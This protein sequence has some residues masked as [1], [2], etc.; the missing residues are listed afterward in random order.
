MG[1]RID[2]ASVRRNISLWYV[3]IGRNDACPVNT[4][5]LSARPM[6]RPNVPCL[7]IPLC[8][9][10]RAVTACLTH[11]TIFLQCIGSLWSAWAGRTHGDL[12]RGRDRKVLMSGP[13]LL[14]L[15]GATSGRP[16]LCGRCV[17]CNLVR[18][19][20]SVPTVSML[21]RGDIGFVRR[22]CFHKLIVHHI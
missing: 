5:V 10:S 1:P 14:P 16:S 8:T 7:H 15:H 19:M 22:L 18:H 6:G 20:F 9:L 13:C 11:A 2:I 4:P 3:H 17:Q 12:P 21:M